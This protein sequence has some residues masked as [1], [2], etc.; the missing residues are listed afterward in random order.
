MLPINIAYA[1]SAGA[2]GGWLRCRPAFRRRQRCVI[3]GLF[4][5]LGA[6]AAL[7]GEP[8]R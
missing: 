6:V 4:V 2:L 7:T 5:T 3:G 8:R 1:S